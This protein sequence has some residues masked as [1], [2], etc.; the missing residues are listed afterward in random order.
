MRI[1]ENTPSLV[2]FTTIACTQKHRHQGR[3]ANLTYIHAMWMLEH[4]QKQIDVHVHGYSYWQ[5]VKVF[6]L[7][8]V[9]RLWLTNKLP[10][11]PMKGDP[12]HW[13]ET[14]RCITKPHSLIIVSASFSFTGKHLLI[15]VTSTQSLRVP[16]SHLGTQTCSSYYR[17]FFLIAWT[18]PYLRTWLCNETRLHGGTTDGISRAACQP[19]L[20]AKNWTDPHGRCLCDGNN[21]KCYQRE[22]CYRP[23]GGDT[24]E[25]GGVSSVLSLLNWGDLWPLRHRNE[26]CRFIKMLWA[27]LCPIRSHYVRLLHIHRADKRRVT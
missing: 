13:P 24:N 17:G 10:L 3:P 9:W 6:S 19:A 18:L 23:L 8:V 12:L 26:N 27:R 2:I 5:T 16:V 11:F 22:W 14:S 21:A 7:M 4:T 25:Y 1:Y 15:F 20:I